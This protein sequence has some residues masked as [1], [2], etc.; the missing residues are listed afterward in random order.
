MMH[1]LRE[2]EPQLHWIVTG[3]A[4]ANTHMI[5]INERLG[6]RIMHH[7]VGWQRTIGDS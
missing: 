6:Y 2:E 4:A 3:N 5:R 7:E 1:W